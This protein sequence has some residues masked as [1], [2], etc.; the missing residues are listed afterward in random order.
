LIVVSDEGPGLNAADAVHI[1]LPFYRTAET[2]AAQI[3]G[4]GLGLTLA[5]GIV[6]AHRGKLWAEPRRRGRKGARFLFTLPLVGDQV[7]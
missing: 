7:R 2:K 4:A 6:E 1:F 3:P 5:R